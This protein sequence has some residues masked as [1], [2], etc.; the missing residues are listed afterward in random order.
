LATT[1]SWE[2]L[3]QLA[4]FRAAQ[5]C[6]ISLYVDLDPS[7]TPTADDAN[8]RVRSLIDGL[9]AHSA[10]QN[11]LTHDQ[12]EAL[13]GDSERI[14]RWFETDFDRDGAQAAAVFCSGLDNLW[15]SLPLPDP[16]EDA[17]H[18]GRDLLLTPLVPLVGRSDGAIVAV[19][20]REEGRL[21]RLGGGRLHEVADLREDQ[22]GQHDQGGWSQARFRR[23][24]EKLVQEHVK[25]VAGEVGQQA[26]RLRTAR[27]VI[28]CPAEMR[29][30]VES[31]LPAHV[32]EA[33]VGWVQAQAHAGPAELLAA[34]LPELERAYAEEETELVE[35]WREEAGRNGRAAAGWAATL[36]AASDARVEVLLFSNGVTH[37]AWQ[38]PAC[39]R[40]GVRGGQCPLDGTEMDR[41]SNG[42]DLAVHLTLVHGGFVR[43]IRNRQDLDPV[44]GI[45][46]LLRF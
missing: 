42:L 41:R 16:V 2:T 21:Y 31:S 11:S 26:R 13:R 8:T 3:R 32:R 14:R 17:V 19:V 39:G 46:A 35:R 12:R 4:E 33:V 10:E 1:I 29:S 43:A 22:P 24:I 18:L 5:G 44:E 20:S 25:A 30:E 34:V 40:L 36:E 27:L 38:C 23:H 45:G 7:V 9:R 37:E 28:V 15:R 6:A